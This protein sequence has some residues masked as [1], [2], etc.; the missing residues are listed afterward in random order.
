MSPVQGMPA[1]RTNAPILKLSLLV[2]G[3]SLFFAS[4]ARADTW[5]AGA[6]VTYNQAEWGDPTNA[7]GMLLDNKFDSVYASAGDIFEI[8][9]TTP[10]FFIIFTGAV[11]LEA[12]LPASGLPGPL[13]AN[14]V[15]PTTSPAGLFRRRSGRTEAES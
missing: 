11:D 14:L 5:S 3:L 6:V 2:L 1:S 9:S 8:G 12:F 15:N 7:A 4:P 13:D 10:G